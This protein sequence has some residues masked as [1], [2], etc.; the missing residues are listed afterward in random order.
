MLALTE[1]TPPVP[2]GGSAQ[3]DFTTL[4]VPSPLK[5]A[6]EEETNFFA[7]LEQFDGEAVPHPSDGYC[8]D[9]DLVEPPHETEDLED[10]EEEQTDDCKYCLIVVTANPEQSAV[11]NSPD[12]GRKFLE[13]RED[14]AKASVPFVMMLG[15]IRPEHAPH[16]G[17]NR[18]F[19]AYDSSYYPDTAVEDRASNQKFWETMID[20]PEASMD[21]IKSGPKIWNTLGIAGLEEQTK[22]LLRLKS[23]DQATCEAVQ[24][25]L[26]SAFNT[27]RSPIDMGTAVFVLATFIHGH[28]AFR[29]LVSDTMFSKPYGEA[30][31][32]ALLKRSGHDGLQDHPSDGWIDDDDVIDVDLV[33]E[34][35]KDGSPQ[36]ESNED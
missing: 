23:V 15:M 30:T 24:A 10:R 28:P 19:F 35:E 3:A 7:A 20:V 33:R 5:H 16:P 9:P 6:P 26:W 22:R 25:A 18:R 17:A 12:F 27:S 32:Y 13:W 2:T 11:L 36:T 31:V 1:T 14:P 4:A 34:N 8:D 21:F 29:D